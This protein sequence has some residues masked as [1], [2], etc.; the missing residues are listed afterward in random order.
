[1]KIWVHFS[2]DIGQDLV[3]IAI[4]LDIGDW[5]EHFQDRITALS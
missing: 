5:L 2:R 4:E 3:T 1:M